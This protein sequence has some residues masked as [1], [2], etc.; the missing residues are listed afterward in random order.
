M[1]Y[2]GQGPIV[3]VRR[4]LAYLAVF[5]VVVGCNG[6]K[7]P[8]PEGLGGS[9]PSRGYCARPE[10]AKP[11]T[12]VPNATDCEPCLFDAECG[13]GKSC[14]KG[15]CLSVVA[16]KTA[17]ECPAVTPACTRD[18][19]C[20]ECATGA[21]CGS[22]GVCVDGECASSCQTDGECPKEMRCDIGLNVC[23]Q[24]SDDGDCP[25]SLSCRNF[26]CEADSCTPGYAYCDASSNSLVTCNA[27]GSRAVPFF[28]PDGKSCSD[29][30]DGKATCATQICEPKQAACNADGNALA[31]CSES[32]LSIAQVDCGQENG[33]CANGACVDVVCAPGERKCSGASTV[34]ECS[35]NG[36]QIVP[37]ETCDF[38][39]FCN[40]NTA[41]CETDR[42]VAGSRI[43]DGNFATT[44]KS[45]GS[46]P[47]LAGVDCSANDRVCSNGECREAVCLGEYLCQNGDVYRCSEQG[48]V[49]TLHDDCDAAEYCNAGLST[50]QS[51]VCAADQRFCEDNIAFRC[52]ALGSDT[53]NDGT[54]CQNDVCI[55]GRCERVICEAGTYTCRDDTVYFCDYSGT[56]EVFVQ[57]CESSQ[58]CLSGSSFCRADNCI[59]DSTYCDGNSIVTCSSDGSGPI[60]EARPCEG[61]VCSLGV[62][63]DRICS[64][65]HCGD[66]GNVYSCSPDGL[67][68]AVYDICQPNER[69]EEGSSSCKACTPGAPICLGNSAATCNANGSGSTDAGRSCGNDICENGECK[70]VV[71]TPGYTCHGG[72]LTHC[73]Y[74]GTRPPTDIRCGLGQYCDA[75]RGDCLTKACEPYQK[76]CSGGQ[77]FTCDSLGSGPIGG[78]EV[79]NEGYTCF[80]GLCQFISCEV[81]DVKCAQGVLRTCASH[82]TSWDT[83]SCPNG[84]VCNDGMNSCSAPA[85]Q[86]N[87]N[88]CNGNEVQTCNAYGFGPVGY[89]TDCY[90]QTC[91]DG[92]CQ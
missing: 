18:G 44:C 76:Y 11:G 74:P 59:A 89:G 57:N 84:Q 25:R 16:C 83:T 47:G 64:G 5:P 35:S 81:G 80:G 27:A 6:S 43:C 14:H 61:R 49:L 77:A 63:R 86:P 33:V 38:A 82:Q 92:T 12:P 20:G 75:A 24:C 69:C 39:E 72:L 50:C 87:Q 53:T 7:G 26:Q 32:G 51:T 66:D 46:G 67:A 30:G 13:Q 62:C 56:N 23:V 42:C 48:T 91:V 60:G 73:E 85:C 17:M 19:Q 1:T 10:G 29:A 31:I 68:A 79:C 45:D 54:D 2:V 15:A 65:Y 3:A 37:V 8:D 36:T 88:Y 4:L 28:C 21:D 9:E 78:V 70:P 71:C 41:A 90:P 40:S 58:Y 22:E 34:V 52:N 55:D